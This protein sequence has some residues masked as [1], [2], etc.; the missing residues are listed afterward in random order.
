MKRPRDCGAFH[1]WHE[2]VVIP[3]V[4][5]PWDD[6]HLDVLLRQSASL[7]WPIPTLLITVVVAA[8]DHRDCRT[9]HAVNKPVLLVDAPRVQR[10][11]LV[12]SQSLRFADPTERVPLYCI[13]Q[14]P[15]PLQLCRVSCLPMSKVIS[16]VLCEINSPH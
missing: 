1:G 11:I 5:S 10:R 15:Y 8:G 16:A 2:L 9:G 14:G 4:G 7:A 3:V 13:Q 6:G 12:M